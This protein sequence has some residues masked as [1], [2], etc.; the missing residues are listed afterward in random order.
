MA[1]ASSSQS[2]LRPDHAAGSLSELAEQLRSLAAN[3]NLDD[4]D[5]MRLVIHVRDGLFK[6]VPQQ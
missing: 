5:L 3:D 1:V 2:D 6:T 4:H